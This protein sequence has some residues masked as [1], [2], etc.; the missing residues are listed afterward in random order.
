[1]DFLLTPTGDI[2][3]ELE[4]KDNNPFTISFIVS[5]TEALTVS[6]YV[7]NNPVEQYP[8]SS[9]LVR[10]STYKPLNNKTIT[11]TNETSYYE[12]QI[13]MRILTSIGRLGS[14]PELGSYIEKYKHKFIDTWS[15]RSELQDE[16]KRC[17]SDIVPNSDVSVTLKEHTYYGFSNCLIISIYDKERQKYLTYEL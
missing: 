16:V 3:F 14:Y 2:S 4:E 7:D 11:L 9:L 13:K 10:F 12:Q 17:I 5:Q 8:D 1:M 15:S 6:F